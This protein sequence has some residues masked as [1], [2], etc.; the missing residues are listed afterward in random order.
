[1][2]NEQ[3]LRETVTITKR[4]YKMG[5]V[6]KDK[7][8]REFY[9]VILDHFFM[10]K[11][12]LLDDVCESVK[13]AVLG[14]MPELRRVQ[15]R[16][17]NGRKNKSM[18]STAI[19]LCGNN[20]SKPQANQ[21]QETSEKSHARA[22]DLTIYSANNI[23]SNLEQTNEQTNSGEADKT[24][25]SNEIERK[26]ELGWYEETLEEKAELLQDID[27]GVH[28]RFLNLVHKVAR[29][30][31]GFNIQGEQVSASKVL[32]RYISLFCNTP[33]RT[34][35]ILSEIFAEIDCKASDITN[36]YKYMASALY[37]VASGL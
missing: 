5:K 15:I 31:G 28:A 27:A 25:A 21:E 14:V 23:Y 17:D 18:H 37:N 2:E 13:L 1:M 35:E 29:E 32:E 11:E 10:G 8:R 24:M 36:K 6:L 22:S 7:D 12:I 30:P 20:R 3:K 9:D 33:I 4:I 34:A 26:L 19:L 16:F